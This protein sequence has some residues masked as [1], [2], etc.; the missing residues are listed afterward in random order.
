VNWMIVD[1]WQSDSMMD[2]RV[3]D[4]AFFEDEEPE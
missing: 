3:F 4:D 1:V 2:Q